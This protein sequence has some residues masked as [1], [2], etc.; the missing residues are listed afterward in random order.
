MPVTMPGGH[1]PLME[2]RQGMGEVQLFPLMQPWEVGERFPEEEAFQ[3]SLHVG[4]RRRFQEM[5]EM[6][7]G[8]R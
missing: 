4:D 8:S 7:R 6:E 5:E 1:P 2:A 3:L